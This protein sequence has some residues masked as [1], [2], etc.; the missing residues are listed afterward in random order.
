MTSPA[1]T[2]EH[3]LWDDP[4]YGH[5]SQLRLPPDPVCPLVLLARWR[6]LYIGFASNPLAFITAD[7]GIAIAWVECLSA[8][9]TRTGL[10]SQACHPLRLYAC[11]FTGLASSTLGP[12]R[13]ATHWAYPFKQQH[14]ETG[15]RIS[16]DGLLV[17]V[18]EPA[19]P[20]AKHARAMRVRILKFTSAIQ[21]CVSFGP[22]R[23]EC[24]N[25]LS[26]TQRGAVGAFRAWWIRK[27]C[28]TSQ[29]FHLRRPSPPWCLALACVRTI[30]AFGKLVAHARK[31][32][33]A[34]LTDQRVGLFLTPFPRTNGSAIPKAS[35]THL[36]KVSR[37]VLAEWC[38]L[39]RGAQLDWSQ[40][41]ATSPRCGIT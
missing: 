3:V 10:P 37:A 27:R 4:L 5:P 9:H 38:D 19:L 35:A 12:C 29:A 33:P 22:L 39:Q 21:T 13:H 32:Q 20:A 26:H 36:I 31:L 34:R 16:T 18:R 2:L 25:V 24:G 41:N 8:Y 11:R 40:N 15:G 28:P 30:S 14:A 7:F 17:R 23:V 1:I 6:S